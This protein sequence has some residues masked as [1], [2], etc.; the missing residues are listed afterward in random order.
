[1]EGLASTQFFNLKATHDRFLDDVLKGLSLSKKAIPP[2]YFYDENGSRLFDRICE[3]EE[4]Y[5]TR[6]ESN[7]LA[8]NAEDILNSLPSDI[9]LIELGS[10]SSTKT[11]LLLQD[12][13][14]IKTYVPIDICENHLLKSTARLA[15]RFSDIP[16]VPICADYTFLRDLPTAAVPAGATPVV[17][18]PG[19]TI[20]NLERKETLRLLEGIYELIKG[21]GY[22]L[23]G[24]DLIKEKA[25]LDA[26]YNDAAGFTA[27]FN[28]NLLRRINREL[29]GNFDLDHFE[30][31][32]FFNEELERVEMHLVSTHDQDVSVAGRL[33]HFA[34][35]ES[36]HTESSQKYN[37]ESFDAFAQ[38]AGFQ[39][40]HA[41]TD[42]RNR[43]AVAL[44]QAFDPAELV[45]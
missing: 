9:S 22:F 40:V 37:L 30:H 32:A 12:A 14:S 1:M 26:A 8:Q 24:L 34:A 23:V 2:K 43:F 11:R 13:R 18:F 10:G 29:G 33:F 17:F 42:A 31:R 20:G 3:T 36:I 25:I 5:V 4:Y 21:E 35:G 6:T 44:L 41:W 7:I 15:A 28:R 16:M 45:C 39:C 38:Q 19:S 27:A